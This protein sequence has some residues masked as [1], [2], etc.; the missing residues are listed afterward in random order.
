CRR[1]LRAGA[2]RNSGMA[3][4]PRESCGSCPEN[5]VRPI[6]QRRWP[7]ACHSSEHMR[8]RGMLLVLLAAAAAVNLAAQWPGRIT[9]V[10]T[11]MGRLGLLDTH[12]LAEQSYR[13]LWSGS[14]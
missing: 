10:E 9:G 4:A 1:T 11:V 12:R 13:Q 2:D 5:A 8:M 3:R 7:A 14:A 6:Q